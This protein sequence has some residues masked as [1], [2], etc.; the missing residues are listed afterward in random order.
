MT[1]PVRKIVLVIDDDEDDRFMINEALLQLNAD[2]HIGCASGG[3]EALQLLQE[4][5]ELDKLPSLIIVDYNM[6]VMD[7]RQTLD[8]IRSVP[9]FR[10]IP[11]VFYT[12]ARSGQTKQ[13]AEML[14]ANMYSKADN[15]S[16]VKEQLAGMLRYAGI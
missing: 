9:E 10:N 16:E 14:D 6:P 5:H 2:L 7:G 12:T 3:S 15:L 4:L 8:R 1:Y 13:V 11:I